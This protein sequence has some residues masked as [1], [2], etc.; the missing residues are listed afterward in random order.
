MQ[1]KLTFFPYLPVGTYFQALFQSAQTFEKRVG[2][3]AG[4]GPLTD[5]SGSGRHKYA[6]PADQ[7]P[8][9]W[10]FQFVGN[11]DISIWSKSKTLPK[12]RYR[13]LTARVVGNKTTDQEHGYVR[14]L[15]VL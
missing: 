13:I 11:L 15:G 12:K 9:H 6:D 8:K 10:I 4:S 3:G 14:V 2:P 5:G 1:K 7:N